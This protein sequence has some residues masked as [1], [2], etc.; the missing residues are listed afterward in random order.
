N[1]YLSIFEDWGVRSRYFSA[2]EITS[3]HQQRGVI[4]TK[5]SSPTA[6]TRDD[7]IEDQKDVRVIRTDKNIYQLI[8][9]ASYPVEIAN[10]VL[11]DIHRVGQSDNYAKNVA[12]NIARW[13]KEAGHAGVSWLEPP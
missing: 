2:T 1:R 12:N 3:A 5:H 13:I 6:R 4:M 11:F 10:D 9:G 7:K 8:D